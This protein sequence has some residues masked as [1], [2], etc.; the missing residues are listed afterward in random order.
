M[1]AAPP[2]VRLENVKRYFE[3]GAGVRAV[4]GVSFEIMHGESFGL[5]GESGA[6]KSTLGNLI[7]MLDRPTE[8][9]IYFDGQEL[10][11]MLSRQ[12]RILR[13]DIQMVFQDPFSS[14]NPRKTVEQIVRLPLDMHH[15]GSRSERRLMVVD[16]LERVG[17][18]PAEQQLAKYPHEFSGGQ[19]QRIAIARALVLTPKFIVADE[20][21]SSLDISIRAQ[22]LNLMLDL[23]ED[24]SLTYL[25]IAHDLSVIR[26]LCDRIAVMYMGKIVEL[27][28]R[29]GIS[30]PQHPYTA[31]LMNAIPVPD[32]SR[33]RERLHLQGEPPS[34]FEPPSGCSFHPR[35]PHAQDMCANEEPRLR[36]VGKSVVACHY[37][38]AERFS[39]KS[40]GTNDVKSF[41]GQALP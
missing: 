15:I 17:L 2:M 8:G 41:A 19:Q 1:T 11:S 9:K 6:G 33:K 12:L 40:T 38:A 20:P 18:T 32:L 25:L 7:A 28:D 36:A 37:P 30:T 29:E 31:A 10:N 3:E 13:S 34:T 35:C 24:Y 23:K 4:D 16:M 22:V 26:Y 21:V 27:T 39:G 5:V 14:L